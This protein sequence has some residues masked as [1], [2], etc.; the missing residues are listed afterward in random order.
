MKASRKLISLFLAA[1]LCGSLA[2]CSGGTASSGGASSAP[3]KD[4]TQ[5]AASQGGDEAEELPFVTL[6]VLFPGDEPEDGKKVYV[7]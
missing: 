5:S 1:A 7:D 3:S 2:S 6:K 4:G